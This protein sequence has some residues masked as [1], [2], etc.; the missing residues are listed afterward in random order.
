MKHIFLDRDGVINK[1]PGGWTEYSYVT[2]LK[3]FL[4]LPGSLDAI[5][6]L[7][8]AGYEIVI[9]SNQAGI[10]KGHYS[11]DNLNEITE[12]MLKEIKKSGGK[13]RSVHYCPHRTEEN[14]AC[15]KPRVGLFKKAASARD[16]DF[17]KTYFV[18]DGGM[19]VEAGK[20]VGCKT[21]LV[22]S[23]KSK[24]EDVKRWK[25]KPD[26]IKKDLKE[27]VDWILVGRRE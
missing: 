3:E 26:F 18:G 4:F 23:G 24:L 1:D 20:E 11:M 9:I 21:I 19:D 8:E 10:N 27:A 15:R 7:T 17:E 5:R 25:I 16:I 22:L 14:C 12:F 2:N 6:G 13:I